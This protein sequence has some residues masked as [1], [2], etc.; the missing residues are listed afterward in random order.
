MF[1]GPIPMRLVREFLGK[2][3]REITRMVQE[4]Q[5]PVQKMGTDNKLLDKVYLDPL[6]KWMNKGAVNVA[7]D[8]EMLEAALERAQAA[9]AKRDAERAER[10]KAKEARSE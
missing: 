1:S 5:F 2:T 10:N 9:I 7:W 3:E 4:E 8:A 6:L